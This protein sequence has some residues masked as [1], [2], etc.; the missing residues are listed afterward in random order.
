MR[1]FTS[2]LLSAQG[3]FIDAVDW[4]RDRWIF[5]IIGAELLVLLIVVLG[6]RRLVRPGLVMAR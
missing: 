6:R 2:S 1:R 3:G 5:G 4:Q